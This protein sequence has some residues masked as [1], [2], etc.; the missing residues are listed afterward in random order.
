MTEYKHYYK[1]VWNNS[2]LTLLNIWESCHDFEL[3]KKCIINF[4]FLHNSLIKDKRI[5]LHDV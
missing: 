3:I 2:E 4:T 5:K 1:F